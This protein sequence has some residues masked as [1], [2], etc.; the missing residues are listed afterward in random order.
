MAKTNSQN[1]LPYVG[2]VV[3][4]PFGK[5]STR[6][7]T[8]EPSNDSWELSQ[9][10]IGYQFERHLDDGVTFRQNARYAHIDSLVS[11]T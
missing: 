5:I 3:D 7:F 6:L 8:G 4:A 9:Q 10:M 1:F 2:T 11:M